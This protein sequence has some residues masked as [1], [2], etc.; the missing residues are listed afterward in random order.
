[1]GL[2]FRKSVKLGPFRATLSKSGVSTSV[3]VKGY[4]VTKLANGKTMKTASIPGTGVSH[5]TVESH[6]QQQKKRGKWPLMAVLAA[7]LAVLLI[8]CM[9]GGS[10]E[11][12]Q[13]SAPVAESA[14]VQTGNRDE[15][16]A[17][18]QKSEQNP[19]PSADL[20]APEPEPKPEP[21]AE[22]VPE[23]EPEPVPKPEPE[24]EPEPEPVPEPAPEPA[25][26]PE[27]EP[28]PEPAPVP[29]P[30]PEPEPEPEP[31][32]AAEPV[33]PAVIGNKNSKV[34]HELSCNSVTK[35]KDSNKVPMDSAEIA[36][37]KGYKPCQ[38]CH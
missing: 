31:P 21:V 16:A 36:Q 20:P 19:Q 24:P 35:M 7:L 6:P 15:A 1:M 37:S 26:K 27:P 29:A 34:Y 9:S 23:P 11:E 5:V 32:A 10:K 14:A 8:G 2:R 22:P 33:G 25:P 28:V 12:T 4:R 13:Q 18:Q 17:Q 30:A 3:G 38:N